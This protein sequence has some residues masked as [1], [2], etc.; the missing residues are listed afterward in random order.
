MI[1]FSLACCVKKFRL[2]I[3]RLLCCSFGWLLLFMFSE[4]KWLNSEQSLNGSTTVGD[5]SVSLIPNPLHQH[6]GAYAARV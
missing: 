6:M 4:F 2:I 1:S 5:F 3:T